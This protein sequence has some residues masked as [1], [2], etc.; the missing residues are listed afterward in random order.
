[1]DI[2]LVQEPWVDVGGFARATQKFH[3]IY[4]F[5]EEARRK[6]A[7]AVILLSTEIASDQYI[8]LQIESPDVVGVDIKCGPAGSIR[9]MNVY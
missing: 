5:I 9:V 7:R 6:E 4:P 3:V 2:V 8:T 1:Y